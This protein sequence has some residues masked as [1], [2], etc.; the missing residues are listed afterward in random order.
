MRAVCNSIFNMYTF[1][2]ADSG[3]GVPT[4]VADVRHYK[5]SCPLA[6]F[7]VYR[8]AVIKRPIELGDYGCV[9]EMVVFKKC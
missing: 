3:L 7:L 5:A 2:S 4:A 1:G 9:Q 6:N 8:V